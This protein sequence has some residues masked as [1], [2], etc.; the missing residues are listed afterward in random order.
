MRIDLDIK[1]LVAAHKKYWMPEDACY[2]PLQVGRAGKPDIGFVGD[3][4]GD[5]ISQKNGNYCELTG[6]YW[7][8]K[9]LEADYIG[10]VH[11]RRHFTR[12]NPRDMGAKRDAVFTGMDFE[13]VLS[14]VD[15]IVPDK[16]RYY[17]ET[18]RSH[19]NHAHH[20]K[21]LDETGRIIRE[22][23]PEYMPAFERVMNRRW[24]HMFNMFVMRQ[25]CFSEYAEWLFNILFALESRIDISNYDRVE[26][27]VF[28]FVSELLLD[29]WLETK[30]IPY[31][32][33]N[34]AFMEPQNWLK[35][36]GNFLL[37]KFIG[38]M[39]L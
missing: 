11:Y 10:L 28:G 13:R 14:S 29:V 20:A 34:V 27:R 23:Y 24:A 32:E 4:T 21:D 6:V 25:A 39:S 30:G 3:D 17:I 37:R 38:R 31:T 12:G 16:R 5:S 1:I 8:W 33:V 2:L 35:K 26:A 7:A 36:G 22:I 18:N 19:Y 15:V 9:N